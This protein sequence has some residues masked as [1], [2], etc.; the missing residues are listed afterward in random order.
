[1]LGHTL[2]QLL[3]DVGYVA[4]VVFMLAEGCGV[5]L[6]A[7]MMLLTA[8]AYAARG[9]ISIVGVILC[10]AAGGVLGGSAGYWIGRAGGSALVRR[11]GRRLRFDEEKLEGARALFRRR[12]A[13]A[14][15]LARFISFVRI[16]VP[17]FAGVALMPFARFSAL[18]AAGALGASVLYG[19]LGYLFGR[20]LQAIEHDIIRASVVVVALVVLTAVGW[21]LKRRALALPAEPAEPAEQPRTV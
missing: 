9:K 2:G 8:A 15:F 12:G 3:H 18:N 4:V 5:P 10:G 1:M 20:N 11:F 19:L 6:P 7:E 21:I 13:A 17:M 16:V 14:V